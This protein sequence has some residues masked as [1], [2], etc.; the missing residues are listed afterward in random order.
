[1]PSTKGLCPL[2]PFPPVPLTGVVGQSQPSVGQEGT[3]RVR[4]PISKKRMS[5]QSICPTYASL[6]FDVR[7]EKRLSGH[8]P[9]DPSV[10]NAWYSTAK[11][12]LKLACPGRTNPT[13]GG[14]HWPHQI[15]GIE[16]SCF[17]SLLIYT[18]ICLQ[19]THVCGS[20]R[21]R[22]L[23]IYLHKYAEGQSRQPQRSS[24]MGMWDL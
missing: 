4:W 7:Q 1:M 11:Y 13:T 5:T 18:L 20:H 22:Q 6:P 21:D 14:P 23:S 24:I 19:N 12:K 17:P 15:Q 9:L 16:F 8:G 3:N 2:S 10:E